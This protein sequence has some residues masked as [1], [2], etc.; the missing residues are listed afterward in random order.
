MQSLGEAKPSSF[1]AVL[2]SAIRSEFGT[3][4][5]F[6]RALGVTE[7][8]VSQIVSGP[9][10]VNPQTLTSI[11]RAFHSLTLQ[12]MVHA[13]WSQE[14]APLPSKL[15]ASNPDQV[16]R[17]VSGLKERTPTRA[18]GLLSAARSAAEEAIDWQILAEQEV[19]LNLRLTKHG[20]AYALVQT[21]YRRALARGD[22]GDM[23]TALWMK[24]NVVRNIPG[25][26]L[27]SIANSHDEAVAFASAWSPMNHRRRSGTQ[28]SKTNLIEIS[29][30]TCWKL[31]AVGQWPPKCFSKQ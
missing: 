5:E 16:I 7:G 28:T 24:G 10:S 2:R 19:F 3:A 18:L 20:P 27:K 31:T 17:E 8:R 26:P 4:K 15:A 22:R 11:L 14:F 21:M 1:G 12:E 6:A 30:W 13:A 9:E 29:R 23:L 25:V